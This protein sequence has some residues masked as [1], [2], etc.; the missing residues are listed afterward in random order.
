VLSSVDKTEDSQLAITVV[1][2][3]NF[4]S[5][6]HQNTESIFFT[7]PIF[8]RPSVSSLLHMFLYSTTLFYCIHFFLSFCSLS[9]F[10]LI[11]LDSQ[12]SRRPTA[13]LKSEPKEK[14]KENEWKR[15]IHKREN[16]K[17]EWKS[18]HSG[19]TSQLLHC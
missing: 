11:H 13:K 6:F 19:T 17:R 16:I 15:Y 2:L 3:R 9:S 18:E 7:S 10:V 5:I 4:P 1:L 12:L 8:L 14:A